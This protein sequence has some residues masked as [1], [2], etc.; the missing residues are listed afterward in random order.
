MNPRIEAPASISTNDLGP[1]LLFGAQPLF[2]ARLLLVCPCYSS[3]TSRIRRRHH[4][5]ITTKRTCNSVTVRGRL[6][7]KLRPQLL[8]EAR[9]VLVQYVFGPPACSRGPA[10]I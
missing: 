9:P 7:C 1:Q 8:F 5:Q 4:V 6:V 10:S 2:E 3:F